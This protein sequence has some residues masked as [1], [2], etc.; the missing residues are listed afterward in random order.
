[1][2]KL[3]LRSGPLHGLAVQAER[4]AAVVVA[5]QV[6][7]GERVVVSSP[8]STVRGRPPVEG[9]PVTLVTYSTTGEH[10]REGGG[11]NV[12]PAPGVR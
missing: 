11:I 10:E 1:M 7:A 3:T 4:G 6:I 2:N 12:T 5:F 9:E 8:W